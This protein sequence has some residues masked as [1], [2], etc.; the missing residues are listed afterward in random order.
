LSYRGNCFNVPFKN[1][2]AVFHHWYDILNYSS[3][4][5]SKDSNQLT[6]ALEADIKDPVIMGGVLAMAKIEKLITSP[7]LKK[8]STAKKFISWTKLKQWAEK[9]TEVLDGTAVLFPDFPPTKDEVYH[10]I[11][12]MCSDDIPLAIVAKSKHALAVILI[13]LLLIV[14]RA[15]HDHLPGGKYHMDTP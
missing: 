6:T 15:L 8:W 7:L 1:A 11:C 2:S 12:C 10:S 9:P 3:S 14:E 4:L 13:V 5:S